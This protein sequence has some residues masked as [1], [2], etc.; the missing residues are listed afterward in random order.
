ME[1]LEIDRNADF[2]TRRN[3]DV[4]RLPHLRTYTHTSREDFHLGLYKM[5][6]FPPSCSVTFCYNGRTYGSAGSVLPFHKSSF[7]A[8]VRRVKFKARDT[9]TGA[10]DRE[11]YVEGVVEIIDAAHRRIR[12]GR[13]VVVEDLISEHILTDTINPLYPGFHKD[14]DP[15]FVEIFCVEELALWFYQE[16]GR[17]EEALHHLEHIRTLILSDTVVEPYLWAL[18]PTDATEMGSW[19]CLELDT[20]VI[21]S[22]RCVDIDGDNILASI[23][24]LARR[25]KAVG[26]P[27]RMVSIFYRQ[28]WDRDRPRWRDSDLEELRGCVGTFEFVTGDGALDWKVDDYFLAGLDHLQRD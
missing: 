16:R 18:T 11:G 8:D 21:H 25:R 9:I 20:L 22:R 23:L 1:D 2:Y 4:V 13:Q 17:V 19:R 26:L 3:H 28:S 15:R 14:L 5:L 6:S 7:F 10:M 24:P 27:L 12:S